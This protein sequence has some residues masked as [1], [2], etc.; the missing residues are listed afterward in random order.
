LD[1]LHEK[2]QDDYDLKR[3]RFW[4]NI[5]AMNSNPLPDAL[6]HEKLNKNQKKRNRKAGKVLNLQSLQSKRYFV[7]L[8]VNTNISQYDFFP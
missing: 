2:L 8:N 7:N 6:N 1:S 3:E 5:I 4:S